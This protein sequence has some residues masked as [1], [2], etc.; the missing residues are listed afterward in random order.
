MKAVIKNSMVVILALGLL[1]SGCAETE[2]SGLSQDQVT[3]M[4]ENILA[5]LDSGN[6]ESF[7]QDLSDGMKTYFTEAQFE[8]LQAMLKQASGNYVSLDEPALTNNQGYAIYRFPAKFENETVY[9]SI[10]FKVG[11][12]Q[13]EGIWFDSTNLRELPKQ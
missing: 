2:P 9:M 11:G 4:A 7:L 5:S 3:A 10:S 13:V 8:N 1:L 12:N 6:Y